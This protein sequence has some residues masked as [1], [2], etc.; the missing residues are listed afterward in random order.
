MIIC[1]IDKQ[2]LCEDY[3]CKV[4]KT[5]KGIS[6]S[7]SSDDKEK[8]AQLHKMSESCTP[9]CCREDKKSSKESCC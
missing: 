9:Q 7:F 8:V 6:L 2:N 1:C 5:E 3:S 4:E